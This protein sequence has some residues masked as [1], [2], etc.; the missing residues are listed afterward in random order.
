MDR[1]RTPPRGVGLHACMRAR[2]AGAPKAHFYE[3]S[4]MVP[5]PTHT[6]VSPS[7][8]KQDKRVGIQCLQPGRAEPITVIPGVWGGLEWTGTAHFY[9]CA[10]VCRD[11]QTNI[12]DQTSAIVPSATHTHRHRQAP[13]ATSRAIHSS[14]LCTQTPVWLL[15]PASLPSHTPAC[16]VANAMRS[17][18]AL[19]DEF[20]RRSVLG[21]GDGQKRPQDRILA[22][23]TPQP[24]VALL[25]LEPARCA[26]CIPSAN[27]D[28]VPGV[29][30]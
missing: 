7:T 11:E 12:N 23:A 15:L 4:S 8:C 2:A 14:I 29:Q 22:F 18:K 6:R 28:P 24:G 3:V 5:R 19:G 20:I 10:R 26:R 21:D 17:S 27:R 13:F 1:E 25:A 30:N 16:C 9:L